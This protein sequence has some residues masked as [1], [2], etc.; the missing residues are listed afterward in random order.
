MFI[1]GEPILPKEPAP[2]PGNLQVLPH[3]GAS[4]QAVE[5]VRREREEPK[6]VRES[7]PETAHLNGIDKE[8]NALCWLGTAA[9]GAK[10]ATQAT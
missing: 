2:T 8:S 7:V 9:C 6:D 10:E 3:E 1:I 5:H 4:E